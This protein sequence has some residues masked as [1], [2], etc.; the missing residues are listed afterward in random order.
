[1]IR[2][3]D[4]MFHR[5]PDGEGIFI[6]E[7]A[8]LA[9]RRLAIIDLSASG[10]Q[11]M[12]NEDQSLFVVFNGEIFN[13]IELKQSLLRKGHIF[14]SDSDT[15]V[16][17]HQ[18]EEDGV[19]CLEKFNGMFALAI[20]DRRK[21]TLF[22]ARDRLG[23]KPLY[24]YSS[25]R[26]LILSSE[27]KAILEDPSV[28]RAA[29]MQAVT[30][31]FYAGRALEN[32]TMFSGIYEIEPGWMLWADAGQESFHVRRY[33]DV[34]YEYDFSRTDETVK[35]ELGALLDSAVKIHS[36]SDAPLGNHLSGGLDSSVVVALTSRYRKD[37]KTFS[38]K[39]SDDSSI[40]ETAYAK[41]VAEHVGAAYYEG[42]PNAADMADA[43]PFLIWHMDGPM[44]SDG[45]F[46][47]YT[48]SQLARQHVKVSMTG[49]GGDEVFA[50]YPAQFQAAYGRLD[51]FGSRLGVS[52]RVKPSLAKRLA[53]FIKEKDSRDVIRYLDRRFSTRLESLEE[54]WIRLHC[55]HLPKENVIFGKDFVRSL[56]GYS[57][58]ESY[59]RPFET[60]STDSPLDKCLYHDLR[61]YLPSLLHLEDRVSM[62]VSIE[63]RVPLLDYRIVE[64]LAT[65]PPSQKVKDLN[66]KYLLR[67]A[68]ASLLPDSI[69][70]RREKFPFPVPPKFWR[71]DEMRTLT[72]DLLLDNKSLV[73]GLFRPKVLRCAWEYTDISLLWDLINVEMWFRLF[74]D[75]DPV[76]LGKIES[77][78]ERS[79]THD[80][81]PALSRAPSF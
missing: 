43:L 48:V 31:Y 20:W 7:Y 11:P 42:R 69:W 55:G 33:W 16:I 50:G 2:M 77:H 19:D 32:K 28:P 80:G 30:D 36:R 71:T 29:N 4:T 15:E 8:C 60:V 58:R 53:R 38:I 35:R 26:C 39:F 78:R 9:H 65:V 1:M 5:G 76:W 57:P 59:L 21:K 27:I 17:L 10:T 23:I 14:R 64:F 70:N 54:N 34:R 68:A 24:Y 79:R 49:H 46:A 12:T 25:E 45:G 56:G 73:R 66:P 72:K 51:M 75:R 6:D 81:C 13:Y 63:S 18:Y 61:V 3:R 40:D 22:A 52:D 74:I 67:E 62:A 44:A 41:T 37:L 47:Y